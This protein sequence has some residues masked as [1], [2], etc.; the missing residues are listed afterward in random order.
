ME[1]VFVVTNSLT[2]GGAERAMNLVCAELSKK[3]QRYY[4][5]TLVPIN[6]G[7]NDLVNPNCRVLPIE[8]KWRGTLRD[9][10]FSYTKFIFLIVREKPRVIILNCALP[11]LFA[12]LIPLKTRFV[13][14]EHS[15]NPWL[16]REYL[17]RV[18]RR[19]L[20]LRKSTFVAV[21]A[22]LEIWSLPGVKTR[23]IPNPVF[24]VTNYPK[25]TNENLIKRLVFVG[26]L[27]IDKNPQAFIEILCR[28]RY[29]GL[30]IGDGVL[31]E[32]IKKESV[33]K[34]LD[35]QFTGHSL[36]PWKLF[37]QGD[38]LI[39][40]SKS[41]GDGL[42]IAEAVL[43]GYPLLAS[44][45]SEFQKFHLSEFSYCGT[46]EAFIAR[47]KEFSKRID[48]LI[49]SALAVSLLKNERGI[50]VIGK[51]WKELLQQLI[52]N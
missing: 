10:L 32:E 17:G 39:V 46:E 44:Q 18:I 35:V 28:L 42:V 25:K 3:T 5:I 40:P 12:C 7:K 33:N 15:R 47:I 50:E 41:E 6:Q 22:H 20:K 36:E 31:M 4:Q 30:V 34:F 2:G 23:I 14:V 24:Q 9:T 1:K 37:A 21:S 11:E 8:R 45:I 52:P 49:P 16:G 48:E 19:I 43:G 29:P 26:R 13:V 51:S 27:A 38:L